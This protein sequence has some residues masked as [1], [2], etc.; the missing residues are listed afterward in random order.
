VP[1]REI[2]NCVLR[3]DGRAFVVVHNH[4]SG[5]ATPSEAD[6][7]VTKDLALAAQVVGLHFL[8]HIVFADHEWQSVEWPRPMVHFPKHRLAA[9]QRRELVAEITEARIEAA[10]VAEIGPATATT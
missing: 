10:A 1:I 6:I 2:L 4:P 8:D 3:R 7:T 9:Q 5:D